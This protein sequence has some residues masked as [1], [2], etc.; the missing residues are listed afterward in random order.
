MDPTPSP[1][2][3]GGYASQ[4]P[5]GEFPA[6]TYAYADEEFASAREPGSAT[7]Q[8]PAPQ[9]TPMARTEPFAP[10][11]VQFH[12][13]SP[14]L[15]KVRL[16]SNA[17]WL[18][19]MFIGLIALAFF[20]SPEAGWW[21]WLLPLIPVALAVWLLWLIPRQVRAIAY[22]E[23]HEDLLIRKGIMFRNLV[24]VPYGRLQYVDVNA[25]PL[26]RAFGVAKVQLHTASAA[27]DAELPG[28]PPA[29]AARL[30][31]RLSEAGEAQLAGL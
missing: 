2:Q 3:P 8:Q 7:P 21:L 31:D 16:I 11:G 9:F 12:G 5:E 19:P 10:V 18:V 27:T 6:P 14:G 26:D 1:T 13:V 29:E 20:V 24:V 15:A 22:A 28:L 17:F 4:N 30:R 23:T 25:G